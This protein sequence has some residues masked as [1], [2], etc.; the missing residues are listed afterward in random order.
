M[1]SSGTS[2]PTP[3]KN[4]LIAGWDSGALA[5]NTKTSSVPLAACILLATSNIGPGLP[6]LT[7]LKSE[8][9]NVNPSSSMLDPSL[10]NLSAL[11]SILWS[12]FIANTLLSLLAKVS[13]KSKT[14]IFLIGALGSRAILKALSNISVSTTDIP[15]FW[16]GFVSITLLLFTS[17]ELNSLVLGLLLVSLYFLVSVP[18]TSPSVFSICIVSRTLLYLVSKGSLPTWCFNP[19]SLPRPS[20]KRI[21]STPLGNII[22]L[23]LSNSTLNLV[24]LLADGSSKNL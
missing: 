12:P 1:F 9:S 7:T 13:S 5:V 24:A 21:L 15:L 6:P 2:N 18:I 10:A 3:S 14:L 16:S 11:I 20:A 8:K 19:M 4:C 23:K 17:S 22:V